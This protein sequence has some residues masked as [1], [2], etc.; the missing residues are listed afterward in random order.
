MPVTVTCTGCKS[1]LKVRD[2]LAGKKIKCPKCATLVLIPAEDE[3]ELAAVEVAPDESGEAP[4]PKR[5]SKRDDDEDEEDRI[6]DRPRRKSRRDD[7]DDEDDDRP[8]KRRRSRDDD[9]ED[10]DDRPKKKKKVKYEP[11]PQCDAP[12]PQRVKWTAWG[13]FYGPAMLSHVRCQECGYCYNGKT[14][15][16]NVVAATIFVLVPL[17]G[18]LTIVGAVGYMLWKYSQAIKID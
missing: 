16:S 17:I 10:D 5:R 14:G 13:S 1:T 12:D 11:C 3:E 9:D 6:T 7:D 18:I 8:R 15:R 2:D 4:A